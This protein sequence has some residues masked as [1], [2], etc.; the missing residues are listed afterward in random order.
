MRQLLNALIM[1]ILIITVPLRV[2]ALSG[3]LSVEVT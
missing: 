3:R 2:A 1:F